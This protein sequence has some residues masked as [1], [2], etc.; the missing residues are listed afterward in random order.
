MDKQQ[1]LTDSDDDSLDNS[2]YF[3]VNVN[4]LLIETK[5]GNINTLTR[6]YNCISIGGL[7]GLRMLKIVIEDKS[8]DGFNINNLGDYWTYPLHYS[9]VLRE[10]QIAL[11][12][13]NMG[14]DVNL[15]DTFEC[16]PLNY[17]VSKFTYKNF[18]GRKQR[19]NIETKK[20][21]VTLLIK[22]ADVSYKCPFTERYPH[23]EASRSSYYYSYDMLIKSINKIL[24]NPLESPDKFKIL[25][26][27]CDEE[28]KNGNILGDLFVT[29]ATSD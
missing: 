21:L 10:E 13:I 26:K 28:E 22:G 3:P 11:Y 16:S 18:V 15:L 27:C 7:S 8:S 14:A 25:K 9:I 12:L 24:N 17:A 2:N 20:L 5:T 6:V 1:H 4:D 19:V 23:T 29:M